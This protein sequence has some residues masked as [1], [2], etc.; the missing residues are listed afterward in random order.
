MA[1]SKINHTQIP[2]EFLDDYLG[3]LS[4][5]AVKAFLVVCRKTIGW[6]KDSDRL[7][8]SQMVKIAGISKSSAMTAF[9]E[10]SD[11]GLIARYV[12]GKGRGKRATVSPNYGK[13]DAPG[14]AEQPTA[15][16]GRSKDADRAALIVSKAYTR[17]QTEDKTPSVTQISQEN[18]GPKITPLTNNGPKIDPIT[19]PIGL[20]N[21]PLTGFNGPNFDPSKE[22]EKKELNKADPA[23][24]NEHGF[25]YTGAG[26]V[27]LDQCLQAEFESTLKAGLSQFDRVMAFHD[28]KEQL[29]ARRAIAS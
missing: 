6:H 15:P 26:P 7:P 23:L 3:K 18:N 25:K 11:A 17:L 2:N 4:G 29:K 8:L 20:K 19:D 10:L 14:W 13:P 16:P 24:E 21:T 9:K 1:I 22:K 12:T 27:F 28:F 5:V